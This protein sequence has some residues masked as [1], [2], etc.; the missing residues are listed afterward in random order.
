MPHLSRRYDDRHHTI[1]KAPSTALG[2]ARV[3][4]AN[5]PDAKA[6]FMYDDHRSQALHALPRHS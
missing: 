3:A 2:F 6:V 1:V 5:A 4:L